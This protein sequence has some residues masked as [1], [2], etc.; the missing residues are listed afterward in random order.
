MRNKKWRKILPYAL[1]SF[2]IVLVLCQFL[3]IRYMQGNQK[4]MVQSQPNSGTVTFRGAM[5]DGNWYGASQVAVSAGGWVLQEEEDIL[6]DTEGNV[7]ELRLPIGTERTLVF[8]IGPDE[9]TVDVSVGQKSLEWDLY[10][11]ESIDY[12]GGFQL[13]YVRFVNLVKLSIATVCV[14]TFLAMGMFAVNVVFAKRMPSEKGANTRNSAVEFL[15]FFISITVVLHHFTPY[16]PS[17]YLG[18]DFFF[19]LSGFFLMDYYAK[20]ATASEDPAL[21]AVKYTKKRYLRLF[22]YYLLAFFLSNILSVC[23]WDSRP[24]ESSIMDT[25]WEITMLEAFGD[26]TE[27]LLVGP[28]WYCSA[29]IIAGFFVYFLLSKYM[30]SNSK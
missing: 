26:F 13:P 5:I 29:L 11:A 18:V 6:A 9:G 4:I 24:L 17:G 21:A 30:L 25:F 1:I 28:G 2:Y 16:S 19:L 7:L 23:L 3:Q 15:R 27:N 8:N 14:C 10:S 22:P 20:D 12:G